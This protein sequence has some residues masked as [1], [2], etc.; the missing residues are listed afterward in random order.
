MDNAWSSTSNEVLQHFSVNEKTGL[1]A[2]QVQ[3]H[4]VL[5]GKNGTYPPNFSFLIL[6][7]VGVAQSYLKTRRL[8]YGS[9]FSNNSKISSS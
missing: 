7:S 1:K 6:P 8:H 2:D 9:S 4:V 3:R 5:Y